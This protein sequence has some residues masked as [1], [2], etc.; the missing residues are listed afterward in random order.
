M[1]G[2]H[3]ISFNTVSHQKSE[4]WIWFVWPFSIVASWYSL[5]SWLSA[6]DLGGLSFGKD[7]PKYFGL[8]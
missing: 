1:A 3:L 4:N 7:Y 6:T 5:L 2:E 8:W